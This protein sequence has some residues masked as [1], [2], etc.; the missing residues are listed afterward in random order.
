MGD[1]IR[2]GTLRNVV[3]DHHVASD[4]LPA[5]M[6]T[7]EQ[8]EA[9]GRL[10]VEVADRLK[11]PLGPAIAVPAFV[12]LATDT[13]WFRFGSTTSRTLELAARLVQAGAVPERI[14]KDLYEN[15]TLG[16]LHLM[17]RAL[18]RARP[19]WAAG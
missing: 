18:T 13:G 5:E 9:T 6:F 16:R 17:G 7:C 15:D 10:V 14:Y 12:A 8:A 11:V 19:S 2:G 3:L 1:V 4:S